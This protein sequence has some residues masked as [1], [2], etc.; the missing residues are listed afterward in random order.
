MKK[1]HL[2]LLFALTSVLSGF[3]ADMTTVWNQINK[4]K[5]F[6]VADIP[7]QKAAANGFETLTVAINSAPTSQDI[8]SIRRLAD[9][10]DKNQKITNATQEGVDVTIYAA[11]ADSNATAYKL[12]FVIDKDDNEDK[13]L[14]V[15]YGTCSRDGLNNAL[16]SLSIEDLIGG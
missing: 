8:N 13:A 9:T 12:M 5:T 2:I 14:I 15:L 16:Q 7:A 10:I 4:Q 3:A 1:L 6:I 11:P